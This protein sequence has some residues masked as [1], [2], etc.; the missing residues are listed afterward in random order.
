MP[1][2]FELIPDSTERKLRSSAGPYVPKNKNQ[3]KKWYGPGVNQNSGLSGQTQ[4][5]IPDFV[6]FDLETTGLNPKK[7][8]VI[9]IGAVRFCNGI[10]GEEISF[11]V[12][13][14]TSIPSAITR[15]TGIC[16]KDVADALPF[17][18][19]AERITAFIGSSPVCGHQVEFDVNFLNEE[20]KRCGR[21]KLNC[22]QLDTAALSRLI[23]TEL[24]GFTLGQVSTYLGVKLESAHRALD[25]ARA[26]GLVAVRLVPKLMEIE[27]ETCLVMARFAPQSMIKSMLFK[28]AGG[29]KTAAREKQIFSNAVFHK[30]LAIPEEPVPLD[31]KKISDCFAADGAAGRI[32]EGYSPRPAQVQMALAVAQ[33][34]NS[35]GD[36]AAEAGTGVG[37]S[38]AYLVPAAMWAAENNSR[39]LV[40]AY[41]RNVGDQLVKRDLPVI[42]K[43]TGDRITFSVLKGRG[44]YLCLNR[45]QRLMAGEHGNLSPRERMAVL[46]LIRWAFMTNS[47]D[48]EEQNLFNR[49]WFGKV[50]N[51]V[52]AEPHG[53][54][55]RRCPLFDDCFLQRAR[56]LAQSS[57]IVVINHALF[58]SE[59]CAE[60]SFLGPIGPI[61]FDEAHHLQECGHRHLRTELD[62]N[63][64]SRFMELLDSL[65]KTLHN[66][67]GNDAEQEKIKRF[68]AEV[69]GIR[70][71]SQD[72]LAE[73][74]VWAVSQHNPPPVSYQ[75]TYRDSPFNSLY[76]LSVL[77]A[78]IAGVL[79]AV[80]ELHKEF[81]ET[82]SEDDT[83]LGDIA[84]CV[85]QSSQFKADLAYLSA[86]CTEDHVFWV[87]GDREKNWVKLCGVPLDIG[88][89]L[90]GIWGEKTGAVVFTSATLSVAGSIDYF[91]QKAGITSKHSDKFVFETFGMPYT[92]E[93]T[94]K[95]ALNCATDPDGEG[96]A[97]HVAQTVAKLLREFEKNILVLF[98]S[99]AML[100]A[101][102]DILKA[103]NTLPADSRILGQHL[104]GSRQVMLDTFKKSR[105]AALLGADSF[106]EGIDAPGE[107]CEIVIVTRL[108]FLV[109]THPLTRALAARCEEREGESFRSFTIPEALI[110]FR[111]G[112]GRLIRTEQDRGAVVVLD[113]RIIEKG[114][115][116]LFVNALGGGFVFSQNMEELTGRLHEF[117]GVAT[118]K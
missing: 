113:R 54:E 1:R 84:A 57:N 56:R 13:P 48:I 31:E 101:V 24:S 10:K 114:Y 109:P 72:F 30:K 66:C 91:R 8:R 35:G 78:G 95:C 112:A 19:I 105:R 39:V 80:I 75:E 100:A 68:K 116:K 111:Q 83:L 42:R 108:P 53:C 21:E 86:G 9:E 93:Q 6:A 74:A 87:E 102:Y 71:C 28:A 88:E 45:W 97:G 76:S 43:L 64:I 81:R 106:W 59:I 2:L 7:D 32:M 16:D 85:D 14:Q 55:G 17:S 118:K 99:N 4:T 69:K 34:L 27:P 110:R 63:R 92:A 94:V 33:T 104:S 70:K 15:L 117:F 41:T 60:S 103:D 22:Q 51:L 20:F 18:E 25:D 11:F 46:P 96:Y 77:T 38:M 36:L 115:G 62:T 58:F 73:C 29:K 65:L 12:N 82:R 5:A 89:I 50:W 61:I 37:K 47:G 67:H 107:E 52:S 40:S 79:D 26:S 3:G 90:S 23:L 98:T 49:K 44:N